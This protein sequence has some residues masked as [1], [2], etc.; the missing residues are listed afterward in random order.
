MEWIL[1]KVTVLVNKAKFKRHEGL[2]RDRPL[3]GASYIYHEWLNAAG[4][5]IRLIVTAMQH[6][7]LRIMIGNTHDLST[8]SRPRHAAC[9]KKER[10]N[11][12]Q[13]RFFRVRRY[14]HE[15]RNLRRSLE[16]RFPI[17]L[18]TA[19]LLVRV[20]RRHKIGKI[21]RCDVSLS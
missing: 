10:K 2:F 8:Y 17:R 5:E 1:R 3:I 11:E 4:W 20:Y 9:K 13:T 15:I 16:Y 14:V 18:G 7:R 12:Q 6:C 21:F 19:T